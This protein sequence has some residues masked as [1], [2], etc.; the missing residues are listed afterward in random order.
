MKFN[1]PPNWPPFPEGWVPPP[2]WQAPAEWPNPPWGWVVWLPDDSPPA[3]SAPDLLRLRAVGIPGVA[4]GGT[5]FAVVVV[6]P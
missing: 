3:A 1:P 5:A 2:G 6:E 4:P